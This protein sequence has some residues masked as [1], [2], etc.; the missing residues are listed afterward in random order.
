MKAYCDPQGGDYRAY[1]MM[2]KTGLNALGEFVKKVLKR[3]G[4][5]RWPKK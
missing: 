5:I 3:T 4:L 1:S 2:S